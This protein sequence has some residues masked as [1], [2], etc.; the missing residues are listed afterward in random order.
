M[1]IHDALVAM[2]KRKDRKK[3]VEVMKRHAEEP[4]Q[5]RGEQVV[6]FAEFKHS[7]PDEKGMHRWSSLT[8]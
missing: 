4:L 7:V 1:N 5:I 6:I 2:N 3:V 8:T